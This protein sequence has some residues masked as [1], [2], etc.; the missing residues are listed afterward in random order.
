MYAFVK[1]RRHTARDFDH[2]GETTDARR[3]LK[4][5][6][7][8]CSGVRSGLVCTSTCCTMNGVCF[9]CKTAELDAPSACTDHGCPSRVCAACKLEVPPRV[10]NGELLVDA[11]LRL[12]VC[13]S[14]IVIIVLCTAYATAS[15]Y[16]RQMRLRVPIVCA[17][18]YS[19]DALLY[20]FSRDVY[21]ALL[22]K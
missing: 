19:F 21:R 8:E 17:A 1:L 20:D 2:T 9:V 3:D 4:S 12:L 6:R 15:F 14:A 7:S 18:E 10:T 11:L 13:V 16:D 22:G 5:T